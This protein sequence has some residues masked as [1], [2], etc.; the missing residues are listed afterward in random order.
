MFSSPKYGTF[1]GQVLIGQPHKEDLQLK[2]VLPFYSKIVHDV[3]TDNLQKKK[4][5]KTP[6]T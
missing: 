6:S 4:K 5:K 3:S 2:M 1:T